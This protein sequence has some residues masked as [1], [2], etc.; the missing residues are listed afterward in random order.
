[1]WRERE[2]ERESG[3]VIEGVGSTLRPNQTRALMERSGSEARCIVP[4]RL[5]DRVTL[6]GALCIE[7][8]R[9]AWCESDE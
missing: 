6:E 4:G 9:F 2:R 1:V 5:R 8:Q 7:L 3:N